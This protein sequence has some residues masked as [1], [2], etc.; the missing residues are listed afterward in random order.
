LNI[1]FI[2]TYH[3]YLGISKKDFPKWEGWK[4]LNEYKKQGV[5]VEDINDDKLNVLVEN[6][7]LTYKISKS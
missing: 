1:S 3:N 2:K 4:I 6:I 5:K 7:R